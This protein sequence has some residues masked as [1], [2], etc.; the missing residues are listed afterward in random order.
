MFRVIAFTY[1]KPHFQ[2]QW[3]SFNTQSYYNS[4]LR[5]IYLGERFFQWSSQRSTMS[6]FS[7]A[8]K[9]KNHELRNIRPFR[10][11][12]PEQGS[13]LLLSYHKHKHSSVH[14]E[15]INLDITPIK[16]WGCILCPRNSGT[17]PQKLHVIHNTSGH[18]QRR[19]ILK[20]KDTYSQTQE[21]YW[22]RTMY[23]QEKIKH[24]L[25]W[26]LALKF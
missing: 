9:F 26:C 25:N 18:L 20:I 15:T 21:P 1:E 13:T 3:V 7:N 2:L 24:T 12:T 11:Y 22:L 23:C 19:N 6:A 16:L 17:R 14:T 8:S 5:K 4:S 10:R